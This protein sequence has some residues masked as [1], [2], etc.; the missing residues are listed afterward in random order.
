MPNAAGGK[1][2]PKYVKQI[3]GVDSGNGTYFNGDWCE[4]EGEEGAVERTELDANE[5]SPKEAVTAVKDTVSLSLSATAVEFKPKSVILPPNPN[6][7]VSYA[8][9]ASK[10]STATA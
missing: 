5:G 1:G 6:G 3:E 7:K 9:A 2:V 4:A 8:A 10:L